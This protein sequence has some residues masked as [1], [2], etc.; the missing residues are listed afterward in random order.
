M[1]IVVAIFPHLSKSTPSPGKLCTAYH[2]AANMVTISTFSRG[3][4]GHLLGASRSSPILF[5][6][7]VFTFLLPLPLYMVNCAGAGP[8]F[9]IVIGVQ[10]QVGYH[11]N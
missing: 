8:W 2:Q 9:M 1:I 4:Y 11:L 7:N 6:V 10:P 3:E 5:L